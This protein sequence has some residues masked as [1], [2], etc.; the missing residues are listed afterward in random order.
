MKLLAENDGVSELEVDAEAMRSSSVPLP[1]R[2][3]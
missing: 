1:V 3:R 2:Q